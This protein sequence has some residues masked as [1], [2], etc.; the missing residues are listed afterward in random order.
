MSKLFNNK[1]QKKG[2]SLIEYNHSLIIAYKDAHQ[3]YLQAMNNFN[4]AEAEYVEVAIYQYNA[5]QIKMEIIIKE[6]KK[7]GINNENAIYL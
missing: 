2:E 3:E 6:I 4:S 1:Q 5:A 7:E